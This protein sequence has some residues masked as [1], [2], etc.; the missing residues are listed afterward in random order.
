MKIKVIDAIQTGKKIKKMCKEAGLSVKDIKRALML[1]TP[2]SIYKWFSDKS[3]S[4]PSLDH[5]VI[6]AS[7]LD[8]YIDDLLVLREI[9]IAEEY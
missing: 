1:T 7:L 4:I 9:Q 8:C 3:T 6:L 5:L 2:Q